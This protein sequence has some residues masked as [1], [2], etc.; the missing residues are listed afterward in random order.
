MLFLMSQTGR[1]ERLASKEVGSAM[2]NTDSQT[3]ELLYTHSR[4]SHPHPALPNS[5]QAS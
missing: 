4:S 1:M 3:E 5:S 2:L